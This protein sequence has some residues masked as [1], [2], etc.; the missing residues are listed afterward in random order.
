[1]GVYLKKDLRN[2]LF[3]RAYTHAGGS[4]RR[5][6]DNLG[7]IGKGRNGGVRDMWLGRR[8]IPEAHLEKLARLAGIDMQTVRSGIV[9]K[10]ANQEQKDW[11]QFRDSL[12]SRYD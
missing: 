2:V 9:N 3:A 6:A 8:P 5:I 7:H 10:Q 12:S 11:W 4:L 1:L